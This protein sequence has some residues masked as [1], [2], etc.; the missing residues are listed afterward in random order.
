L[1][2]SSSN[3]ANT[4]RSPDPSHSRISKGRPNIICA[5]P[6]SCGLLASR[7]SER[8]DFRQRT[9][10]NVARV[11]QRPK[12]LRPLPL[13]QNA[14][15]RRHGDCLDSRGGSNASLRTWASS[16]SLRLRFTRV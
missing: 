9:G 14:S 2:N 5:L 4:V 13:D 8:G 15:P 10:R 6:P 7:P 11:C 12:T 16:R 3:K 1:R